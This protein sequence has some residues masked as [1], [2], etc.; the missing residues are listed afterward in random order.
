[1]KLK[2]RLEKLQS[3]SNFCGVNVFKKKK[4][5]DLILLNVVKKLSTPRKSI[6]FINFISQFHLSFFIKKWACLKRRRVYVAVWP[7]GRS[8]EIIKPFYKDYKK[9]KILLY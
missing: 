6:S 8:A 9:F 1:M 4:C 7:R 3:F 5:K 2:C